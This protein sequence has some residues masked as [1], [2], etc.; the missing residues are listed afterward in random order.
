[1]SS[2]VEFPAGTTFWR[3]NGDDP[4]LRWPAEEEGRT[5]VQALSTWIDDNCPPGTDYELV[6]NFGG[7]I[8]A[9]HLRFPV[10]IAVPDPGARPSMPRVFSLVR[11]DD[12]SNVSGT[13]IVAQGVQMRDG[14]IAMRWCVPTLPATWNLFDSIEDV[15]LLN[16]HQ[17]RTVVKWADE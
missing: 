3:K 5:V 7:E 15:L 8:C 11:L 10:E 2:V 1:M 14:A 16:G 9:V 4:W 17:G 6:E 12:V 13:G